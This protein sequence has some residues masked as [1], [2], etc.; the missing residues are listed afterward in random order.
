MTYHKI[1]YLYSKFS[2]YLIN[3]AF[4]IIKSTTSTEEESEI[5]IIGFEHN[6]TKGFFG[7]PFHFKTVISKWLFSINCLF[8]HHLDIYFIWKFKFLHSTLIYLRITISKNISSSFL[9]IVI[10]KWLSIQ[11]L[12]FMCGDKIKL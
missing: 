9:K 7:S 12:N 6:A 3:R 5:I 8:H 4:F 1:Y 2:F 11:K 10:S